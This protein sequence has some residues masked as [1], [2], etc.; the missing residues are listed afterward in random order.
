MS[1][2]DIPCLVSRCV[3]CAL[4]TICVWVY[5]CVNCDYNKLS[6][7][8]R[9]VS[10]QVRKRFPVWVTFPLQT[11]H[12]PTDS[13][14]C[15]AVSNWNRRCQTW[16]ACQYPAILPTVSLRQSQP[17]IVHPSFCHVSLIPCVNGSNRERSC[18]A[19]RFQWMCFSSL[20]GQMVNASEIPQVSI[21]QTFR[22]TGHS[23][24]HGT[25]QARDHS[26][27]FYF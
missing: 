14:Y 15:A 21:L 12:N 1:T 8:Q 2:V 22:T 23:V 6:E 13:A 25:S 7:R 9:F 24:D 18:S 3:G 26:S 27:S 16:K 17:P 4:A 20:K 19:S 5:L 11:T 10:F